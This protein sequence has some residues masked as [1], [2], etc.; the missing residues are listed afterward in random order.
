MTKGEA[1]INMS[2][3]NTWDVKNWYLP[4][5]ERK[6]LDLGVVEQSCR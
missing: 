1:V 5:Q 2:G 4:G 6:E 3:Y